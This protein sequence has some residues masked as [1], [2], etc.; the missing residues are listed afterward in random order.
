MSKE[1]AMCHG[2][3]QG[4][5][6]GDLMNRDPEQ[7]VLNIDNESTTFLR[8][9][10]VRCDRSKHVDTMCHYIKECVEESKVKVNHICTDDQLADIL[11]KALDREK[12][13]RC[14]EGSASEL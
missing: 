14:S 13:W 6:H 1:T 7:M 8:E 4:M 9:E 11:T 2:V 5:L 3:W 12:F 10:P